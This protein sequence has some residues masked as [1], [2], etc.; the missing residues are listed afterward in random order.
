MRVAYGFTLHHQAHHPMRNPVLRAWGLRRLPLRTSHPS[1]QSAA[2]LLTE[3]HG[4]C[5]TRERESV[6]YTASKA[7]INQSISNGTAGELNWVLLGREVPVS[8]G[9]Y[10]H[11]DWWMV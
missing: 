6:C 8:L 9:Y 5:N 11:M 2:L 3:G 10:A 7:A 4:L 1:Q